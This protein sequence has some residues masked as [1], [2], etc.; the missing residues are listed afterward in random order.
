M[1]TEAERLVL[2]NGLPVYGATVSDVRLYQFIRGY[3]EYGI[4]LWPG[5]TVVDVGA[6]IGLFALEVLQRCAGNLRLLAFEP[7]PASF[8]HLERNVGDLFPES[9]VQLFPCALAACPGEATFYY[10]PRAPVLS[11]LSASS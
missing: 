7:A 4:P 2:P 10:R 11:S 1:K 3:F 6:N 8:A 9:A 5:M